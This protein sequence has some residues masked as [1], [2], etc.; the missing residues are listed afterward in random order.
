MEI[1]LAEE[2]TKPNIC[3]VI[4]VS[5]LII[6]IQGSFKDFSMNNSAITSRNNEHGIGFGIF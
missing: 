2:G 5:I 3:F 1:I 4:L 6:I